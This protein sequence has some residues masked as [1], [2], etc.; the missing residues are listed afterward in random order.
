MGREMTQE[1]GPGHRRRNGRN[2]VSEDCW[3]LLLFIR[4][5]IDLLENLY[6]L[7]ALDFLSLITS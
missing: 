5:A 7:L 2:K 6:H 3:L 4:S 1:M